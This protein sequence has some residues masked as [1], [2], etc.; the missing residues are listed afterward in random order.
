MPDAWC[1]ETAYAVLERVASKI[2]STKSITVD[3]SLSSGGQRSE[4]HLL[5]SGDRFMISSPQ[6]TSWYDGMS[7]WTYSSLAGE[8]NITEPTSEELAQVNPF[9]II[10]SFSADYNASLKKSPKGFDTVILKS[11]RKN[12]DITSAE[13]VINN[14]THYPAKIKLVMNGGQ[15]ISIEI[16]NIKTGGDVPLS[17]FRFNPTKYPAIPVIDLR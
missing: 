6:I 1:A 12:M 2:R 4:G 10:Q 9:A 16:K 7:Q 13:I 17:D 15:A 14:S 5:L 3:Y 11:K 8:V